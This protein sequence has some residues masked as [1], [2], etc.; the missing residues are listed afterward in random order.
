MMPTRAWMLVIDGEPSLDDI[1]TSPELA[2]RLL[3]EASAQGHAVVEVVRVEIREVGD[4]H[5]DAATPI[6]G[7][8]ETA[9]ED[10][11]K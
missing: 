10:G 7:A 1:A 6:E 8:P 2:A 9:G 5:W 3:I 11:Q 4:E